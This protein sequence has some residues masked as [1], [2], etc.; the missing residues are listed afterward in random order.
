MV[1]CSGDLLAAHDQIVGSQIKIGPQGGKMAAVVAESG[2][3]PIDLIIT[4][5]GKLQIDG[6][7]TRP[8]I[9]LITDCHG[10]WWCLIRGET[11]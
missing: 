1:Y 6:V 10:R 2:S 5:A 7:V 3:G 9:D 8:C 4:R 11:C